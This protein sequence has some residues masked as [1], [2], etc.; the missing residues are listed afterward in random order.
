MKRIALALVAT[1]PSLYAV[2]ACEGR[3][4]GFDF[5]SGAKPDR[6]DA[7]AQTGAGA[8]NGYG[9]GY[10]GSDGS[11]GGG[12]VDNFGGTEGGYGGDYGS[13]GDDDNGCMTCAS[14]LTECV[15]GGAPS[16]CQ[17]QPWC[18]DS[19]RWFDAL[20]ACACEICGDVCQSTCTGAGADDYDCVDCLGLTSQTDCAREFQSC[21]NDA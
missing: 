17:R 16:F 13:G 12:D 15:A 4:G 11:Y 6:P 5:G 8:D 18:P 2:V 19:S 3:R 10:G 21:A 1:M 9:G 14:Y 7:V 20:S